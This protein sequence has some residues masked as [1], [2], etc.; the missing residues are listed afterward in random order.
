MKTI[1]ILII[2]I[3]SLFISKINAQDINDNLVSNDKDYYHLETEEE[4]AKRLQWFTDSKY[5]MFVHLGLYSQLGGRWENKQIKGYSE[6]IQAYASIDRSSYAQLI[7]TFNPEHFDADAL[8]KI[9]KES[10][11]TY[12]VI[13]TK[14]HEGFCLWDSKYTD[15]DVA[16]SPYNKDLI[17]QLKVA[18][19]K[20]GLKFGTYYS[21]LDWHHTSHIIPT[22]G[23]RGFLNLIRFFRPKINKEEKNNYV[24][25]MY[26]QL[27]E[28]IEN[29]D[30]DLIWFDGSWQ[31]WWN[32]EDAVGIYNYLRNLSPS[33]VINDRHENR[34]KKRSFKD[35]KTPEQKHPKK[36]HLPWEA[37]Y[38][39][40]DSWGY[41]M[42]DDEYKNARV[43]YEK[44][45][46]ITNG[47]GNLLLNIGPKGDGEIPVKSIQKLKEVKIIIDMENLF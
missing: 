20:Y 2:L 14:H 12:V 38:T 26:N 30:P 34:F 15:F 47:G 40:N 18:C 43:V 4:I 33:I 3:T 1:H 16:N 13:T 19:D 28:L 31:S 32:R 36:E 29:Y 7:N 17:M 37:C 39:L 11:M 23:R 45:K 5:G 25:Y 24:Q 22:N 8:V 10:G 44:L 9:A 21:V 6:W 41:D 42:D 46:E 27:E 35:Y